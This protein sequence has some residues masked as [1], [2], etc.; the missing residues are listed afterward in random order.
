MIDWAIFLAPT[1]PIFAS[2]SSTF[3]LFFFLLGIEDDVGF[4]DV[5]DHTKG[6]VILLYIYISFLYGICEKDFSLKN[7]AFKELIKINF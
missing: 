3:V 5:V 1:K 6:E 4:L 7:L 2:E